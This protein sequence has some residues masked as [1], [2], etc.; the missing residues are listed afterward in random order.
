MVE[1]WLLVKP[2]VNKVLYRPKHDIYYG[3]LLLVVKPTKLER[4][5][6]HPDDFQ[7]F[8]IKIVD[9]SKSRN[10]MAEPG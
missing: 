8:V 9:Q 6:L 2:Q 3:A 5:S 7:N 4:L 1:S 10:R